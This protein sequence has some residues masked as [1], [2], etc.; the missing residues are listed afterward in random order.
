MNPYIL[1]KY[2]NLIT[3]SAQIHAHGLNRCAQEEV[4]EEELSP[5]AAAMGGE[6]LRQIRQARAPPS[7]RPPAPLMT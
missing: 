3:H 2:I 1:L 7:S 6:L 4:V 5:V